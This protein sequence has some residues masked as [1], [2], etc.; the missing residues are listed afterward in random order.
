V[1]AQYCEQ[2]IALGQFEPWNSITNLAFILAAIAA[3][4]RA[5]SLQVRLGLSLGAL[6]A[7]ALAIGIGSFAWH[8]THQ[9]WAELADVIPIL[10]FVLLFWY[11]S[12]SRML[13][14]GRRSAASATVGMLGAIVL[15]A[16]LAPAALNGSAAYLPVFVGL[17][18][19]GFLP[20]ASA[21]RTYLR[22]AAA[23]F[24]VSLTART[25]D[26]DVCATFPLGTHWL[27]HLMNG[28]V[29]YLSLMALLHIAARTDRDT[30]LVA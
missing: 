1:T 16:A 14:L 22:L 21:T 29:I 15:I 28:A 9:A 11:L 24:A 5:R 4:W 13:G 10:C 8:A 30:Q 26:N 19:L 2:L 18:M 27:W 20:P 25:I 6:I 3:W 17:C 7:C 23:C 12:L